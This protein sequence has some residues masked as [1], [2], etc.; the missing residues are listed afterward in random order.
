MM[1]LFTSPALLRRM[2]MSQRVFSAN[3]PKVLGCATF[4][5]TWLGLFQSGTRSS[6]PS[7]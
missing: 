4:S 5:A 3:I 7:S 2:M 6:S 1:A